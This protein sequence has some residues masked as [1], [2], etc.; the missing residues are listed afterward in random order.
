M[1][2]GRRPSWE[3][4][5]PKPSGRLSGRKDLGKEWGETADAGEQTALLPTVPRTR[6]DPPAGAPCRDSGYQQELS[7]QSLQPRD[8]GAGCLALHDSPG[9]TS[10]FGVEPRR[11]G[12]AI[13]SERIK[14]FAPVE[15]ISSA[16]HNRH[17]RCATRA[18]RGSR[19]C[20]IEHGTRESG[21]DIG[22]KRPLSTY[23]SS[24]H[25]R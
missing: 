1:F 19:Q 14:A 25:V 17:R 4:A 20:Q 15:E 24:K 2:D 8:R 21:G 13:L 11:Q 5:R 16:R 18:A 22:I 23:K 6:K 9:P 7:C 10:N 3:R 12:L